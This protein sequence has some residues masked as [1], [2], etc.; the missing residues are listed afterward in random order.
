V[1]VTQ[2]RSD[3]WVSVSSQASGCVSQHRMP[4]QRNA[5]EVPALGLL[6]FAGVQHPTT[7]L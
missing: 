1:V 4:K 5:L 2:L 3:P 6:P 7:E